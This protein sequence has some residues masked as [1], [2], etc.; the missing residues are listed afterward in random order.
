VDVQ[1]WSPA[2][3][4]HLRFRRAT[5]GV[6]AVD[7]LDGFPSADISPAAAGSA[8]SASTVALSPTADPYGPFAEEGVI[9]IKFYVCPGGLEDQLV[10]FEQET[11]GTYYPF[12]ARVGWRYGGL[13]HVRSNVA[14]ISQSF[15][16]VYSIAAPDRA[17]AE[18]LDAQTKPEPQE[19]LDMYA[20]CSKF[21]VKGLG[22]WVWLTPIG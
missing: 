15:A 13:C 10:A 6:Y 16:E 14:Q 11:Q 4:W 1:T 18:A 2:E 7:S 22:R 19:I 8:L 3:G 9:A 12:M 20:A 21:V 5:A 17:A